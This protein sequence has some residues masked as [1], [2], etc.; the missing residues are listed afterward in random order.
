M[1]ACECKLLS[2]G[3]WPFARGQIRACMMKTRPLTRSVGRI[4]DHDTVG[5]TRA[6]TDAIGIAGIA[7]LSTRRI[8]TRGRRRLLL[9]SRALD[10]ARRRGERLCSAFKPQP[11]ALVAIALPPETLVWNLAKLNTCSVLFTIQRQAPC[12]RYEHTLR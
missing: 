7:A 10:E 9:C 4:I 5:A 3:L 1:A 2:T 6:P 11:T 12:P 8:L